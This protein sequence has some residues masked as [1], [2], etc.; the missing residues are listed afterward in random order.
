MPEIVTVPSHLRVGQT[1]DGIVQCF[2][3]LKD[4]RARTQVT[5]LGASSLKLGTDDFRTIISSTECNGETVYTV[6]AGK[7]DTAW[8]R[9]AQLD[10][11]SH[12]LDRVRTILQPL[13]TEEDDFV[14]ALQTL[15]DLVSRERDRA[16]AAT[17]T[18]LKSGKLP[19]MRASPFGGDAP[20]LCR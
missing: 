15:F 5:L 9:L 2:I 13:A 7:I 14:V 20:C 10:E 3:G 1:A 12:L 17:R 11:A 19:E 4:T 8:R 18:K 6:S 16:K